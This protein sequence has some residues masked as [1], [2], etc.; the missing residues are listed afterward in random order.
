[1]HIIGKKIEACVDGEENVIS[2]K[3]KI[4]FDIF[5]LERYD[6]NER[7]NDFGFFIRKLRM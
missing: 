1:M 5:Q 6:I 7:G 3:L 2:K 4:T